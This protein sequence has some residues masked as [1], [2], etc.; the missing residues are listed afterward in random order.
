MGGGEASVE[1][2]R[3]P[4]RE[5]TEREGK[6]AT[7]CARALLKRARWVSTGKGAGC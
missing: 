6:G 3:G 1:V 7:T 2:M 4:I 5:E